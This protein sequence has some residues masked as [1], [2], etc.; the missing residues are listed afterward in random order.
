MN[1]LEKKNQS[2]TLL[3][4][5]KTH[6]I[7][8]AGLVKLALSGWVLCNPYEHHLGNGILWDL[9]FFPLVACK[10]FTFLAGLNG[11]YCLT[12]KGIDVKDRIQYGSCDKAAL[13]LRGFQFT[14]VQQKHFSIY[15]FSTNSKS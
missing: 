13:S 12:N 6:H 1:R 7:C 15:G 3:F 4:V 9:S 14:N 8:Q 11:I 2:V 10:P 5:F